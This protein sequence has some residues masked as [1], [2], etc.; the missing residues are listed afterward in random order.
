MEKIK[1]GNK[2]VAIVGVACRF[3]DADDY[4]SFWNN[5]VN[6][7]NS[8]KKISEEKW[9]KYSHCN[10]NKQKN[11]Y[12]DVC[13]FDGMI[14]NYD[15][16]DAPFF[17]IS[18]REARNMDPQQRILLEEVWHCIEDSGVGLKKLREN[19]TSVYVGSTG[20]DYNLVS[21]TRGE[22][23]D[24]YASLG[25][26][27][28]MLSNRVSYSF[29]FTG[30]SITLDNACASSLVALH[31][32]KKSIL[33]GYSDFAIA[34][35]V[36]VAFHPW[37]YI[38]FSK[39]RMMSMDGKC[40]TFDK[41]AN[42]FVQGEGS[43]VLLLETVSSALKYGHHIYGVIEGSAV[44]HCGHSMTIAAPKVSAQK[45]VI[46]EAYKDAGMNPKNTTYIE[47]HGTGTSLGDPIEIEALNQ[48]FSEYT[49]K[50]QFCYIGSVKTNIGH[51]GSAAGIAGV[52]KVLMM[53]KHKKL[54]KTINLKET[55]PIID[56]KQSAF[57]PATEYMDWDFKKNN[58]K[59]IAGV[60]A[61][62]FGGVNAHV[63]LQEWTNNKESE[64]DKK[65]DESLFF[66]SAKSEESLKREIETWKTYI[67]SEDYKNLSVQEIVKTLCI[68]REQ[69]EYRT[70]TVVH[71]KE[72]IEQFLSSNPILENQHCDG[73]T[74]SLGKLSSD[75]TEGLK[76][77]L[78][79]PVMEKQ[80]SHCYEYE[81]N[82]S[83]DSSESFE[84]WKDML[85]SQAEKPQNQFWIQYAVISSC[86]ELGIKIEKIVS[87]KEQYVL[88]MAVAGMISVEAAADYY[89]GRSSLSDL[90]V[91]R[92][93]IPLYDNVSGQ[94]IMPYY[95]S[96]EYVKLLVSKISCTD[97]IM[98]TYLE[99]AEKL[100]ENQYTF[101]KYMNEWQ[102]TC[103]KNNKNIMGYLKGQPI[104]AEESVSFK[105][106]FLV[107]IACSIIQ[108]STKWHLT[109]NGI[110]AEVKEISTLL[111]DGLLSK[112]EFYQ[113]MMDNDMAETEELIASMHEKQSNLVHKEN[114]VKL[115]ELS[116]E[117]IEIDD[118]QKWLQDIQSMECEYSYADADHA[119]T[120]MNSDMET[121]V[122]TLDAS[123]DIYEKL[124]DIWLKGASFDMDKIGD[125]DNIRTVSLPGYKFIRQR[126]WLDPIEEEKEVA[127]LHPMIDTN[128]STIYE[129]KFR[130]VLKK[131]EFFVKDHVVGKKVILP[132]VAYLEMARAAGQL[133]VRKPITMLKNVMWIQTMEFN[134]DEKEVFI[135]ITP[136]KNELNYEIYSMNG[137]KKVIHSQG[138]MCYGSEALDK[139]ESYDIEQ[140][141][142]KMDY[143]YDHDF[144]YKNVFSDCIGFD[145]GKGFQ[146]TE[147]AYGAKDSS[148]ESLILPE[149]L[150]SDFHDYILHPSILDAALRTITWIGGKDA[151]KTLIMHIPFS[152]GRIEIL[153]EMTEKCYA[154]AEMAEG[155][156][157]NESGMR[158]H[159]VIILNDKG[160][161]VVRVKD[162][163]I[164]EL[165]NSSTEEE[166]AYFERKL[167]Q[168]EQ[169]KERERSF[170]PEDSVIVFNEEKEVDAELIEKLKQALSCQIISVKQGS[171]YRKTE[172]TLYEMDFKNPSHY[173]KVMKQ[174][175][176]DKHQVQAVLQI[177]SFSEE[178]GNSCKKIREYADESVYTVLN[179]FQ[180]AT[181]VC[182]DHK[183]QY[184]YA[185]PEKQD[186][187][188]QLSKAVSI[189]GKS[190]TPVN[191][192]FQIK[193]VC[194]KDAL[195][196]S[197]K[198]VDELLYIE[199]QEDNAVS[200]QDGK[201][202]IG[203][204]QKIES[205]GDGK[206]F[207]D[208]GNYL[209]TGGLGN[210]GYLTAMYLAKNYHAALFLTG[211]RELTDSMKEQLKMLEEAG[212]KKA[213]YAVCDM[214]ECSQVEAVVSNAKEQVGT[215][216][217]IIHCAGF[218]DKIFAD[219][220]TIDS[221]EKVLGAKVY[222][223]CFLDWA[224][225]EEPLDFFLTF[226]SISAV[227]ADYGRG[228]YAYANKFMDSFAEYRNTLLK[229]NKRSG[230]TIS[231][232][233]PIWADGTMKAEGEEE[234]VYK[235]FYGLGLI[236]S[237]EAM[238]V[239]EYAVGCKKSNI[240]VTYGKQSQIEK[241]L[242]PKNTSRKQDKKVSMNADL[243]TLVKNAE[244]YLKTIVG[245]TLGMEP[246]DI[247][248]NV[249]M[250]VYGI[251]SIMIMELNKLMDKDFDNL[252][253]T[254]FFEY[255]NIQD[256][257]VY[258]AEDYKDTVAG[259][260]QEEEDVETEN[261]EEEKE[262][263]EAVM[264]RFTVT[265]PT[266]DE[267]EKNEEETKED[268]A[269][270]GLSGKYPM[271][272]NLEELWKNLK[273]GKD[274]ITEVPKSRWDHSKY[275]SPNKGEKGK[276]YCK[277]AGFMN[278]VNEFDALFFG[279]SPKE[280]E[281]IDPQER[282]FLQSAYE[283]VEDA[284]YKKDSL[285][286]KKVGVFAGVMNGQ[287]QLL[288]AEQLALGNMMDVRSTYAS[289][290]NR[291][292]YFFNFHG[293][294]LSVDTMCSSSLTAIHLACRS[295]Q[296]GE[297]EMAIA[298]GV[299]VIIHPAKFVFL[300][301]QKF[302]SSEGHCRAFGRNGDGYVPAE[303]VGCVLLKPLS[304]AKADG[305][306]IYGVIKA[307]KMNHG[308]K[309][310]GYTVPNPVAQAELI[311]DALVQ[312]DINPETIS[313]VEAH[314]TGTKLGD[315]IEVNSITKAFRKY[316]D[317]KQY[318]CI[319]SIKANIG[320]AESAAGIASL[321]KVLLQMKY[322]QMV[323]SILADPL[324]EN[325]DFESTPFYVEKKLVPWNSPK[326]ETGEVPRRACISSFGAGGTNAHLIIEEYPQEQSEGKA[327]RQEQLFTLSAA[328]EEQ[329]KKY[330]EKVSKYLTSGTAV[331]GE[332]E[333]QEVRSFLQNTVSEILN[334][335]PA[336]ILEDESI[337]E[338]G[339]V[340]HDIIQL[341]KKIND[342]YDA[343]IN[344]TAI[345][346]LETI[347]KIG[348]EIVLQK[349]AG[350]TVSDEQL[351]SISYTM[352]T[353][354]EELEYRVAF[355][356]NS[357]SDL[358]NRL[359]DFIHGKK[360]ADIYTGYV[361]KYKEGIQVEETKKQQ[362]YKE[363]ALEEIADLWTKGAEFDWNTL[364][365][366]TQIIKMSLPSYPF[367]KDVYWIHEVKKD[368]RTSLTEAC[369]FVTELAYD[370]SMEEGITFKNL[371]KESDFILKEHQVQNK[372]VVPGVV[373]VEMVCECFKNVSQKN[374][375]V[376]QIHWL[377][378]L[379]VS[380]EQEV[381]VTFNKQG[382]RYSYIV[383]AADQEIVYSRGYLTVIEEEYPEQIIDI[384]AIRSQ[385][386]ELLEKQRI[387]TS[388]SQ[389]GIDYG[390]YF[391][392]IEKIW[393]KKDRLLVE[394]DKN[395]TSEQGAECY[396]GEPNA[397]DAALQSISAFVGNLGTG[398]NT[399]HVP[400][401]IGTLR[402]KSGAKDIAFIDV[403]KK[404][405]VFDISLAD[406]K[407][408]VQIKL[409]QVEVK[410]MGDTMKGFFYQPIWKEEAQ[411]T[412]ENE[413]NTL[414]LYENGSKNLAEQIQSKQ[415]AEKQQIIA[416]NEEKAEIKDMVKAAVD[417]LGKI[418][419]VY[420]IDK[421]EENKNEPVDIIRNR[422]FHLFHLLKLFV[423]KG[424]EHANIH[425]KVVTSGVYHTGEK[426]TVNPYSG[427]YQGLI[428]AIDA[429][430]AA[431]NINYIDIDAGEIH[432]ANQMEAISESIV[433]EKGNEKRQEIVLW[434][435]KRLVRDFE[436][437]E[438]SGKNTAFKENGVYLI[439]GGAGG[440]G[441]EVSRHLAEKYNASLAWIG[442]S[443]L[444][445][446]KKNQIAEIEKAGGKA[447]Y[448]QADATK[449]EEMTA[450][451]AAVKEKF[452]KLNG[453]IHS[454]VVLKDGM[455]YNM[456]D[457]QYQDALDA[458]MQTSIVLGR[459]LKDEKLDFMLFFSSAQSIYANKGQCNY[460]AGCTFEDAYAI[461]LNN[462][463]E[464]PVKVINW[465]FWGT[466]GVVAD[467]KYRKILAQQGFTPIEVPEGMKAME[468]VLSTDL[469]QVIV[470]KQ[471][472]VTLKELEKV[473]KK[474]K[475][476]QEQKL[477]AF[478]PEVQKKVSRKSIEDKVVEIV[479]EVL[480]I[481]KDEIQL[482]KQFIDYGVDSINGLSLVEM[483]NDELDVT[484]KTTSLFDYP[485]IETM[486]SYLF[487]QVKESL[488]L[489][490]ET[491]SKVVE[492]EPEDS[493]L[494]L[495]EQLASGT[496]DLNTVLEKVGEND[497]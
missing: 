261:T 93:Q 497:D 197:Q 17:N 187:Q 131:E 167:E 445:E 465:G 101:K 410:A 398:D 287:Y 245:Q 228:N 94:Y 125:W 264:D 65:E 128:E 430:H 367:K 157:L 321:T 351:E 293:P 485:N 24:S 349:S 366:E 127:A 117:L 355:V 280:A 173:H 165:K 249:D 40:H 120:L 344:S 35:G 471:G 183:V 409:D 78:E 247:R 155:S 111:I 54:V 269:I 195:I 116:S 42:G 319:G 371:F 194:F 363:R 277:W 153:G 48:A 248:T 39:S 324:N 166:T 180:A 198:A 316:T 210:L 434:N 13:M 169:L 29:G 218:A 98:K 174:L 32:A 156:D 11:S 350:F 176:A 424:W 151:Y 139:A 383:K 415:I 273:E 3:P 469:E 301:E 87:Q 95:I 339:M 425:L 311:G 137:S 312:A 122:V 495:L 460:A 34:A 361:S 257:A 332:E 352:L 294:S 163:I 64:V 102:E 365:E 192:N 488:S 308:G 239:M 348:K 188:N 414:I 412:Y 47:A 402:T 374:F 63:I 475:F 305:D 223:T 343:A 377:H 250:E 15:E 55:N 389:E 426:Q 43:A 272:D 259:L 109:Q 276:V 492:E 172:N 207:R 302:G 212:S 37:R 90:K 299:N 399:T 182:P 333:Q 338:Y 123:D 142:K 458:K 23:V 428:S 75:N 221:Y 381:N 266:E 121:Q 394:L 27:E 298:G 452:G 258:L 309:T 178:S 251:D 384:D 323:P 226:S 8:V 100:Y 459:T 97:K 296:S 31:E 325:I 10:G 358:Y 282:L 314:G 444:D 252:S 135:G 447:A 334:I 376:E 260:F 356:M 292:S 51:T 229:E 216:H 118:V 219:K 457:A 12:D 388:F 26:F 336:D 66:L 479:M 158:R 420:F 88:G 134:T 225:K 464:Y 143:Y 205:A 345:G 114:L 265:M 317:K 327:G 92:P 496:V 193:T 185:F 486:S 164:R 449:E 474:P 70:G 369:P 448:F 159:N 337:F 115:Q 77:M 206:N 307:S 213:V 119:V 150:H 38:S 288:G 467:D 113:L 191:N 152:L 140:I 466:V 468:R 267:T 86:I 416:L 96:K 4:N 196:D 186:I 130:K 300:S 310:N 58:F 427:Y 437:V 57:M 7:K 234:K 408:I 83:K 190:L 132:G 318:C 71:S 270:I 215:I 262:Q 154:Y 442:R 144:C 451:L 417:Q 478:K 107:A 391:R 84:Q 16:F 315:P 2:E 46:L 390:T 291:V 129:Q 243:E 346:N 41:G 22:D 281:L 423:D 56:F 484:I 136:V 373:Q 392:S 379:E 214:T 209:I 494:S 171:E 443:S 306:H 382:E 422:A 201:R 372:S 490:E 224:A 286:G 440:I 386:K 60:S 177:A 407:G 33:E 489:E 232:N 112:D 168:Q 91:V 256:L 436:S 220:A 456:T 450:A 441:F 45:E 106:F 80:L 274:C 341:T 393:M 103:Q 322:H 72:D 61:F 246:K 480:G 433:K 149:H 438:L 335:D 359:Q 303:G 244:K 329:L 404:G 331:A 14:E 146:V 20:N 53:M 429:E 30:S 380:G 435:G 481:K 233:W 347:E 138:T 396:L 268:I 25:N 418:D 161:E 36:C 362:L 304:K 328:G 52:I 342:A 49:N 110:A 181:V 133:A 81:K 73:W 199:S 432:N 222:G 289:I 397:M 238:K 108:L 162:F 313:Y 148:F 419:T 217:G 208:G 340:P 170:K 454:T 284:G 279:I 227:I 453:V 189:L 44:N 62:G 353:G 275:Y 67:K 5:L 85:V 387:Y 242:L 439:L 6:E 476:Y 357:V 431:W 240:I 231:I 461:Y 477:E 354:R 76:V 400:Y 470:L 473:H 237:K 28:C 253:K 126:Y 360:T 104:E 295:I 211:R 141:K 378:P 421:L 68:G 462:I 21:L 482:D 50:K 368:E 18:P 411:G 290:A 160:E 364:F 89:A 255:K 446:R 69:F 493:E 405:E 375:K 283:V 483:I 472:K 330:A 9:S 184:V 370:L 254:L 19:T 406:K 463:K 403:Q 285:S 326:T 395:N 145:Y 320:H 230:Q 1:Q 487:E 147:M 179:W 200:Y 124:L 203:K 59:R 297:S 455:F 241:V 385:C 99:K 175:E 105:K 413:G 491:V 204:L 236:P 235:G 79:S 202:Y 82:L 271:A 263:K 401:G 278:G 74:L